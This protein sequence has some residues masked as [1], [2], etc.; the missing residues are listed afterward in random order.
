MNGIVISVKFVSS[1]HI[2]FL[3]F[4]DEAG[5]PSMHEYN[6]LFNLSL[7]FHYIPLISKLW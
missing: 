7:A 3:E 5:V 4:A 1:S 6:I 2:W